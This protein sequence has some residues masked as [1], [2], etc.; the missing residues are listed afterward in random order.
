MKQFIN[1]DGTVKVSRQLNL[2]QCGQA[3]SEALLILGIFFLLMLGIQTSM[4]MQFSAVQLLLASVKEVFQVHR[5]KMM[6]SEYGN[7]QHLKIKDSKKFS[8]LE[9]K[10]LLSAK[11]DALF[12][13]LKMAQPGSV[14]ARVLSERQSLGAKTI[15]RQSFIEAG[16][17]SASSDRA[18]QTRIETSAS[19]WRD[20]FNRSSTTMDA[21]RGLTSKVDA[22]WK[23]PQVSLE[24]IQPWAAVVPEQS[25]LQGHAWRN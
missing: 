24:L 7:T 2:S 11:A 1:S 20:V 18:V 4:S 15:A 10:H 21:V 17:G 6:G 13:E 19:L 22:A 14:H 9:T 23:R 12:E 5:G 3:M 8:S 16:D 25:L